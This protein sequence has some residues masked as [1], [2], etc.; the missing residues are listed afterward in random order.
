MK[1]SEK[2]M[3]NPVR[4]KN[5]IKNE[6][7]A[8]S[9]LGFPLAWWTLF[10]VVAFF[11]ALIFSF[12][13]V[14]L[15][16]LATG[17]EIK[18][19]LDNYKNL[20]DVNWKNFD[21]NYWDSLKVTMIWT[22][23]MAIGNNLMGML[24][25][26]LISQLKYGKRFFLALLFWPSLVSGVVGSDVTQLVFGSGNNSL[27]NKIVMAL[28][29]EPIQWLTDEK[30][31]LL[32]LMIMPFFL[33]FCTKMLIYYSSIIAIPNMYKEAALLETK[34]KFKIFFTVTLPLMKN[35]IILNTLLSIIDGFKILGPMQLVTKGGYGTESTMLYIYNTAFEDG[36]FG[37]ACAYATILFAIIL[38]FT[39]IQRKVSGREVDDLE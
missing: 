2:A 11:S 3:L 23:A 25:A 9:L 22:F 36:K 35:A 29:Y 7:K 33:G 13:N 21:E 8:Y 27:A 15:K 34:S 18:F 12:T 37:R 24:C 17:S 32:S 31:A 16:S 30:T 26:F 19:T 10:F 6:V 38:I 14:S 28:G 39:F 4:K 5:G 20:F 1:F